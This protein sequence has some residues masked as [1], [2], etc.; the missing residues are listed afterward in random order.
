MRYDYYTEA[1]IEVK[2]LETHVVNKTKIGS[3]LPLAS[4]PNAF[5][6][7]SFADAAF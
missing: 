1:V 3:I 5:Y 2:E 7:G 4:T 6:V